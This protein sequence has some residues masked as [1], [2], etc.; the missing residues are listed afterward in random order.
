[1]LVNFFLP[2]LHFRWAENGRDLVDSFW[3]TIFLRPPTSD[4][5]SRRSTSEVVDSE[6]RPE[7]RVK[8]RP[9][10]RTSS[11]GFVFVVPSRR[12]IRFLIHGLRRHVSTR[13]PRNRR[14][15]NRNRGLRRLFHDR[16]RCGFET[17][18]HCLKIEK[19]NF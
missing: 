1:M 17:L 10:P 15:Q 12:P 19:T 18:Q 3:R 5:P 14:G 6:L 11:P 16:C 4:L 2:D 8:P 13:Q 9:S 7:T